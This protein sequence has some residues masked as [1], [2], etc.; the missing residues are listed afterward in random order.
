MTDARNDRQPLWHVLLAYLFAGW[1]MRQMPR[2]TPEQRRH[3]AVWARDHG[4]TFAGRWFIIGLL[5]WML[6]ISP[7]GGLFSFAGVP[8]LAIF[9]PIAL[10]FG[11]LHLVLQIVAQQR[12]GPPRIDPP[13]D[14][15]DDDDPRN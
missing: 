4:A 7:L 9:F 8:L 10:L 6:H 15:P 13:S 14:W 12:A 1:H 11:L 5:S 3:R 2:D